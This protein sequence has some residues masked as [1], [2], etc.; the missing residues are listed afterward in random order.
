MR[1]RGAYMDTTRSAG[2]HWARLGQASGS[3][4]RPASATVVA[5]SAHWAGDS[6][7]RPQEVGRTDLLAAAFL[8]PA[9]LD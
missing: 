8:R 9:C 7:A 6:K 2:E 3:Q 4:D 1:P 5:E